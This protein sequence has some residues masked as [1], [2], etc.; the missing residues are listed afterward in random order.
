MNND[1]LV[2]SIILTSIIFLVLVSFIVS[3]ILIYHR[4]KIRH[5]NE[6]AAIQYSY[7]QTLLQSQLEIKEQTLQHLA[8]ELHDNLGQ[9]A[10]LVKINL[11]TLSLEDTNK[12]SQK[13]E[14]TKE[15]VR[16]LITD[17]KSLSLSL[18]S[19]RVAHLGL[20]KGLENEVD[21]LNKIGLMQASLEQHGSSPNL[22]YNTTIILYRMMQEILNNTAK[23]SKAKRVVI[24]LHQTE[25]LFTLVCADDGVGFDW[26]EKMK[27]GGSGLINLQA[28]AKLIHAQLHVQSA[29]G[30]GTKTSIALPQ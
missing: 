8:H 29:A 17:L 21:R 12:A 28:R 11:T 14:E 15:L 27:S 7:K 4:R 20:V 2:F 1:D 30:S 3:F 9:V 19:D 25:N 23:H 18:N 16:Q 24:S 26:E 22:D 13:I 5:V 6:I 10:S